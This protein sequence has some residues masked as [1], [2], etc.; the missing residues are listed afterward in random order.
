M[1]GQTDDGRGRRVAATLARLEVPAAT[2][3]SPL[4]SYSRRFKLKHTPRRR[5]FH[6]KRIPLIKEYLNMPF[7]VQ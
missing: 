2:L 6:L 4:L 3:L 7:N 1:D 5:A